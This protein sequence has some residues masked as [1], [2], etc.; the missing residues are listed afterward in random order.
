MTD[1]LPSV[2][3]IGDLSAV[4]DQLAIMGDWLVGKVD[5]CTCAPFEGQH[6]PHCGWEP[7][8]PLAVI[9]AMV[10]PLIRAHIADEI[11][12]IPRRTDFQLG[13]RDAHN[14]ALAM[15]AREVRG[16]TDA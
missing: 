5:G 15:A 6:E 11:Q 12:A 14:A 1:Q 4:A 13:T 2:G 16:D 7:C 10:E 9:V 8:A 3:P